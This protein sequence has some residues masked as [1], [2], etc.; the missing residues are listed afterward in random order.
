MELNTGNVH[1]KP[2]LQP[3]MMEG[4]EPVFTYPMVPPPAV[5]APRT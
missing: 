4:R 3:A 5:K 1:R 2:T